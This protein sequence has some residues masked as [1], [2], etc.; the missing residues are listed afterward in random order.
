MKADDDQITR[1][2]EDL[3]E[4]YA[5]LAERWALIETHGDVLEAAKAALTDAAWVVFV[6]APEYGLAHD[7]ALLR[8]IAAAFDEFEP[9]T[10]KVVKRLEPIVSKIIDR[11]GK[12]GRS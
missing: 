9:V 6:L 11:L 10:E 8:E 1:S 7:R 12:R 4:S 3:G 2:I 5:T